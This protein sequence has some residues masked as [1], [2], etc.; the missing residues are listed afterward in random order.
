MPY[1]PVRGCL[2]LGLTALLGTTASMRTPQNPHRVTVTGGIVEGVSA[3][4]TSVR[5]FLGIPYAAPPV[6]AKRWTAPEPAAPWPGVRSAANF[7][8]RC[9][10]TTPFPDMVFRSPA[11]SEDCLNL[12]I[13]TPAASPADRLPVMVWIHGGGFF[14][15]SSDEVRHEG[16]ALAQKGVVL[17]AIN[18][19]L[20]VLGFLAH[21]E[22]TAASG[23]HASGNYGLLD[24]IAALRWVRDNISGFGGDPGNVTIF[25][26]SA[27]S[28]SVSALM[29]S[30]LTDGLFHRAIGQSGAYFSSTT[31]PLLSLARAEANGLEFA[32]TLGAGSLAALRTK[33][34]AELVAGT[35][36]NPTRFAPIRDGYALADDPWNV[37][38]DGRQRRVPL[39]AGWNSA[40]SKSPP[41]ALATVR[42]ALL[43]Q[44]P[45]DHAEALRV[46]PTSTD[47]EARVSAT[48][49]ASDTFIG[50]NTWKWIESHSTTGNGPVYR[51]LFDHV[52]P[53]ATGH[54]APDDPGAAHAS[55]IEFVFHALESRQLA[56]RDVDRRVAD[57]MVNF[58]TNF[59]RTGNP[60]GPGLP[61][62]PAWS[63]TSRRLM[64]IRDIS[65]AEDEQHR[66]RY[67]LHDRIE[68][69]LRIQ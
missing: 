3:R 38:A 22:L 65:A 59:A 31:L 49:L 5:M 12:S 2:I 40:E 14:S 61:D 8:N 47:L 1:S 37:F 26:E 27:G 62:W 57:L 18:Y 43:K 9:I 19:R 67:E 16:T 58:W 36:P 32:S 68:R 52:I 69:R 48:A 4:A 28:F 29:A 66:A 41:T 45:N 64:R 13:W 23:R 15:G 24:Q 34:P 56:W 6:G 20:G 51:Y 10:Q 63:A 30:P 21:P 7:A 35:G 46:Y 50:Y 44:F 33:T 60:N 55:D 42:A 53:A 54:P 25:G 11:E 39:L 17:V